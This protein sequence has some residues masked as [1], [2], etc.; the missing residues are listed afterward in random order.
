MHYQI[1]P[2][3]NQTNTIG[4]WSHFNVKS[5]NKQTELIEHEIRYAVTR[6]RGWEEGELEEGGQKVQTNSSKINK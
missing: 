6:G 4:S 2:F 3:K 5:K 1:L